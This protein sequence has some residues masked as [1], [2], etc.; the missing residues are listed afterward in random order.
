MSAITERENR[1]IDAGERLADGHRWC[2][3]TGSGCCRAAGTTGPALFEEAGYAPLTPIWPGDPETIEEAR[4]NPDAFAK[5][6]LG[7]VADH[8][9]EMIGSSTRSR[10]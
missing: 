2:S 10:R 4:A 5:T 6:T 8:T 7:Q 1:Q 9:A 3:S